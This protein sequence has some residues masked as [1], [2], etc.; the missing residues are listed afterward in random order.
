MKIV[1]YIKK[2][3]SMYSYLLWTP[4]NRICFLCNGVKVGKNLKCR[5]KVYTIFHGI[6][7]E[8][9]LGKGVFINS[10]R[11]QNPI[12]CGDKT[13]FQLFENGNITIGDNTVI[14]AG[15]VVTKSIPSNVMAAGNP[16]KIIK[17][18]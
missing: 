14:G 17:E 11:T 16:C 5:G 4:I 3:V 8:L 7:S 12:G 13:Y 1:Y 18:L 15:S 6:Q 10:G 2:V 9:K